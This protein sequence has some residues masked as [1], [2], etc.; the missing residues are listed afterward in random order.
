MS[1]SFESLHYKMQNFVKKYTAEIGNVTKKQ[2][3]L[4]HIRI[5]ST[6]LFKG[7][8]KQTLEKQLLQEKCEFVN[9]AHCFP[10]LFM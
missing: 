4:W 5:I 10:M 2:N 3:K 7:I 6:Q 9:A 1:M 8:N